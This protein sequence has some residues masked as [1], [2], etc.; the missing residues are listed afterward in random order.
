MK[1]VEFLKGKGI[2]YKAAPI[3]EFIKKKT[4]E[5]YPGSWQEYLKKY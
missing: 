4:Q 2:D 3:P 5:A 1:V